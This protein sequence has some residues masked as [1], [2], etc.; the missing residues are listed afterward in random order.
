MKLSLTLSNQ[1]V[2]TILKEF[3]LTQTTLVPGG[4]I[5]IE[6]ASAA[7]DKMRIEVSIETAFRLVSSLSPGIMLSEAGVF[8][9]RNLENA[10]LYAC[11]FRISGLEDRDDDEEILLGVDIS[12]GHCLEFIVPRDEIA[13]FLQSLLMINHSINRYDA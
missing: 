2:S 10:A 8:D 9:S 13:R 11:G 1:E 7:G 3:T 5:A 12:S 6:A 4:G